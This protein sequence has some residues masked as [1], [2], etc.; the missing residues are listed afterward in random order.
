MR[1]TVPALVATVLAVALTAAPAGAADRPPRYVAMGD[2]YS[3]ASGVLPPDPDA[4]VDCARSLVNY[5]HVIASK[6]EVRLRDVT[7]GAAETNDYFEK[8]YED[9][10]P[11][12]DALSR[13]TRLV[14]M[15]IGGNDQGVFIDAILACGTEGVLTLGKGN[16]CQ[17]KYGRS[18]VRKIRNKTHPALEHA[19]RAVHRH[20][21]RADV[22]ILGYPW[23]M[24]K[25][26][27]CFDQMPVARG[28]VPY[29]RHIQTVL[30]RVVERS[31]D[32]T[33]TTY[34]DFNRI[35]EGHD[36]CQEIGT[37]WIEPVLQGTDPVIVHPNAL[38]ERRMARHTIRRLDLERSAPTTPALP[39]P[40]RSG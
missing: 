5:P 40:G 2:S 29:L 35:S 13:R 4:S 38:G 18:F 34:V 22:A 12:L 32:A 36:A 30:N 20:A 15:T 24:P 39:R 3:A 37:R 33:G 14:T 28:D 25:R 10:P 23:I 31:A 9:V 21:E 8:Q 19:L 27:G 26:V 1:R 11:Q 16:P 7:C 17:E 6:V